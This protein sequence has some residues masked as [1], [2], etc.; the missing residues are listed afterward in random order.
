M[1]P[2]RVDYSTCVWNFHFSQFRVLSRYKSRT[3]NEIGYNKNTVRLIF[4]NDILSGV[5]DVV[6]PT[7]FQFIS[8]FYKRIVRRY[9]YWKTF[10][11]TYFSHAWV[12]MNSTAFN[13]SLSTVQRCDGTMREEEWSIR[14]IRF[15]INAT[16]AWRLLLLITLVFR[17]IFFVI[18][19]HHHLR[20]KNNREGGFLKNTSPSASSHFFV[21]DFY[22]PSRKRQIKGIS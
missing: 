4:N 1:P 6:S 19:T 22:S 16:H 18:L 12:I 14:Q 20:T 13:S 5:P 17:I 21:F 9:Y 3:L 15:I 11:H 8:Y 2:I 10:E 7:L